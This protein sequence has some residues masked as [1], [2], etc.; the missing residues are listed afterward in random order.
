MCAICSRLTGLLTKLSFG[1]LLLTLSGCAPP[2][3]LQSQSML[4]R[5][6]LLE[7]EGMPESN[8]LQAGGPALLISSMRSSPGFESADM[9]YMRTPHQLEYF[10]RHRWVDSPARMLE[11][12]LLQAAAGI[13][14]FRS[15]SAAGSGTE[16]D[17]RLE[18]HLLYLR[19][20]CRL[21]PSEL[22]LAVRLTLVD[23][24]SARQI[25]SRI[26]RVSEPIN[27]RTPA[28]GVAAANRAIPGLMEQIQGFLAEHAR[29]SLH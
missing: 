3:G 12:M 23:V 18:S 9:A 7:W 27:E 2:L 25:G 17:L 5:S 29:P 21:N 6:Y 19:Q 11:P 22:Q 8:M 24:A 26:L 13:G 4:T 15:V 14:L 16:S 28:A 20:V 10:A 1:V